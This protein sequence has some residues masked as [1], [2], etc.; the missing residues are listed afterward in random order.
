MSHSRP[1]RATPQTDDELNESEGRQDNFGCHKYERILHG[2]RLTRAELDL[3]VSSLLE[4]HPSHGR[5]LDVMTAGGLWLPVTL[6]LQIGDLDVAS[7][8]FHLSR[9]WFDQGEY[10]IPNQDRGHFEQGVLSPTVVPVSTSVAE[11][12]V[13]QIAFLQ[14]RRHPTG[15]RDWLFPGKSS[16]HPWN[17]GVFSHLILQ[18]AIRR[19]GLPPISPKDLYFSIMRLRIEELAQ[20]IPETPATPPSPSVSQA[21]LPT[22]RRT[23]VQRQLELRG[24][25]N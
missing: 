25:D 8:V 5:L 17:P 3:L 22:G 12:V 23:P 11:T 24:N 7:L 20:Q 21:L 4:A 13:Q 2:R 15:D 9:G 6:G 14:A 1:A 19:I 18:P 10:P 16:G